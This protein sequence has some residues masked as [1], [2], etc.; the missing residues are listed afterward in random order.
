VIRHSPDAPPSG[1]SRFSNIH[2]QPGPVT[3]PKP[4]NINEKEYDR[5]FLMRSFE[6]HKS[7][8]QNGGDYD[9][10]KW[11]TVPSKNTGEFEF[12]GGDPPPPPTTTNGTGGEVRNSAAEMMPYPPYLLEGVYPQY[13][14]ASGVSIGNGQ[15]Q[16]A[17]SVGHHA[18]TPPVEKKKKKKDQ[19][20]IIISVKILPGEREHVTAFVDQDGTLL[21]DDQK[22]FSDILAAQGSG[23][24]SFSLTRSVINKDGNQLTVWKDSQRNIFH[25]V[26][27]TLEEV[28]KKLRAK[29][30]Q[31]SS[32]PP[33]RIKT[34]FECL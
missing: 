3:F 11:K 12:P 24:T 34:S 28:W 23:A 1:G 22:V 13:S 2:V 19:P 6:H 21:Q 10:P 15:Q 5:D 31:T 26:G 32:P 25:D 16:S 20:D 27:G 4:T 9:G 7:T 30:Q 18:S 17:S 33:P 14:V 29:K 8:V